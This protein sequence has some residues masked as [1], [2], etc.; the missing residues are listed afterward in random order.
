MEDATKT[1][2]ASQGAAPVQN[3]VEKVAKPLDIIV[4]AGGP[5]SE[6]EVSLASGEAVFVAIDK[7]GHHTVIDDINEENLSA[8]ERKADLVFIA[9]HGEFGEDGTLQRELDQRGIRYTGSG[10]RASELAMHK[11]NAKR[12]FEAAGLP[13]PSCFVA[14]HENFDQLFDRIS[15]PAVIKP[16]ASGSSVDTTI[17]HDESALRNDAQ[18]VVSKYGEALVETFV[19]GP[20]LT[21]AV[22]GDEALPVCQIVPAR[23]FYDYHAKYHANDTRYEFEIDL[24]ETLLAEV[25]RL[26]LAAHTSLGCE[27]FS[28]V[29]FMVDADMNPYI[30]EVNTIPGFTSHSLVPKAARRIGVGFE[31]LCQKIVELSLA[32]YP[33]CE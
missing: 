6:R 25:Q 26:A 30:L 18:Q 12:R 33:Q 10:A 13:T 19:D 14:N 2:S 16:V 8:I 17:A 3:Q 15:A 29:D 24:P 11:V 27:V 9:L 23:E 4:L 32:K 20:E 22:L 21:C 1:E 31:A 5:S 28:R 7:L